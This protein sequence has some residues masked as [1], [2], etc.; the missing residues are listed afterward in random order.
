MNVS[1]F[2]LLF[3]M[4]FNSICLADTSAAPSAAREGPLAPLGERL[5]EYGVKPYAQ[6]WSLSMQN[7]NTGPQPH[8][9][10]NSGNLFFG[11]DINLDTLV[12]LEGASLHV[13]E[14]L[15]ILLR[16]TGVP[17]SR[18][19]PGASGSY[20]GGGS[21]H[22]DLTSNQLSL[23]TYQ[24][25]LLD[26]RLNLTFGR[27]NA[28]RYFYTANCETVI[29]CIDPIIDY[30]SGALPI[31]YGSWGG[32]L[33]YDATKNIYLHSG[34][35]ESNPQDYLR[36]RNGLNFSTRDA[37]GVSLLLGIGSQNDSLYR[38]RYELNGF[39]NTSR[40]PDPLTG[41]AKQGTG[42]AYFKF[43][44]AVWR[45]DQGRGTA[46]QALLLFGSLSAAMN[47]NQPFRQFAEMGVTYLAPFERPQ[48][49]LSLKVSHMRI[50]DKQL[51]AQQ[52]A[53]IANGGD[54]RLGQ[55][56]V[57]A[58]EANGHFAVAPHVAIETSVQYLIRPDN[59][60]NPEAR[61]LSNDGFVVGLQVMVDAGALL[62][63]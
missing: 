41:D 56:N 46:P 55:R 50:N 15:F 11:A 48:D 37:D 6:L 23:L 14:M 2:L 61:H 58:I 40:Q 22:N 19:W 45:A 53:R 16:N 32:Y 30:A 3:L 52:R 62:G 63:L 31:P 59:F 34:A 27:T 13:E 26:G 60:Y 33:K 5:A 54:S 7:L 18:H 24:Q 39:F 9:F 17:T 4:V 47:D 35:F 20:F 57:Y 42:G 36:Q 44:Q 43:Q 1:R 21:L 49:K 12:G 10:G 25:S 38:S 29:T 28:R 8:S 51:I